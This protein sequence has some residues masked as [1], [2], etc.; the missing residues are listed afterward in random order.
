MKLDNVIPY[1]Y[2]IKMDILSAI[3]N[4]ELTENQKIAPEVELAARYGVSRPTVRQ[5]LNELV[6][7]GVLWRKQG[8][9][10]FV[11]PQRIHEDLSSPPVFAEEAFAVGK[12]PELKVLSRKTIKPTREIARALE[13]SDTDELVEVVGLRLAD[14]EPMLLRI[15]YFPL[16][17]APQL[18]TREF[19]NTPMF[20][21][22][23]E[24]GLNTA[25][26]SQTF[27]VAAA[28]AEEA[29]HLNVEPGSP[30]MVCEG[31]NF[32]SDNRPYCFRKSYYRGDRFEFHIQQHGANVTD[33]ELRRRPSKRTRKLSRSSQEEQTSST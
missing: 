2:Q 13:I 28:R 8:K 29:E 26:S 3:Q 16:K 17:L 1:Y 21:V 4:G 6:Y 24:Y 33:I 25:R 32:L 15:E 11:A 20:D 10:T 5:A 9:G 30:V 27:Q 23:A 19:D 14:H 18:S 22:L 12:E 7:T 31:I